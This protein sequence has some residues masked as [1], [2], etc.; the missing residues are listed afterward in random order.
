LFNEGIIALNQ[1]DYGSFITIPNP[2]RQFPAKNLIIPEAPLKSV[3]KK[4][5]NGYQLIN[6]E[7]IEKGG[8]HGRTS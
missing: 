6:N 2:L 4:G 8:C 1:I 5:I 3:C 7:V